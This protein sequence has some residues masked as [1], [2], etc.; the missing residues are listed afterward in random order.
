M[1]LLETHEKGLS[2]FL[3]LSL[4]YFL[5]LFCFVLHQ[6]EKK[7]LQLIFDL[8][9]VPFLGGSLVFLMLLQVLT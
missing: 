6:E 2:V 1:L 7:S 4:F 3:L 8:K 5:F 9:M